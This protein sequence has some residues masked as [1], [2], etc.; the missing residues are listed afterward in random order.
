MKIFLWILV[1]LISI[2]PASTNAQENDYFDPTFLR[3][4]NHIYKESIKT[5]IIERLGYAL[6]DAVL[7]LGTGDILQLSFD[8]LSEDATDYGYRI[9]HCTKDWQ[10][11]ILSENDYIGGFFTGIISKYRPSF[12][13]TYSYFHYTLDFPN[14]QMQV[15]LSGNYLMVVFENAEP[16]KIVLTQRFLVVENLVSIECNI[17][18][19]TDVSLRN[20]HQEVDVKLNTGGLNISN[21]YSSVELVILQN[22]SWPM[23]IKNLKPRFVLDNELDYNYEED[24][25]FQGGSEFRSFDIRTMR[26]LTQFIEGVAYD[27]STNT[28]KVILKPAIRKGIQRYTSEDDIN[29]KFLIK[30]Y[31]DR[32]SEVEADY[33]KVRFTLPV[34]EPYL[35]GKFY[36]YGQLTNWNISP[37]GKMEYDDDNSLYFKELLLKQG[38]YNY[39]YIFIPDSTGKPEIAETEGQHFETRND[40]SILVYFREPGGRYDRLVGYRKAESAGN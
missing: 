18:R 16:D 2:V 15:L 25:V 10:P 40:Y 5:P 28:N 38:Y 35:N 13:T 22:N 14:E 8:D 1:L 29:G 4:E 39:Q 32:N 3:Y 17:H 30:I 20:S 12:N 31:E 7:Q 9:V 26:F 21:P 34:L 24:N 33:V 23:A 19:A 37:E 27:S 6:S 11:S 36:L